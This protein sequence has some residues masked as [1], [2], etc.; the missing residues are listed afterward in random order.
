M[1]MHAAALE[2]LLPP[3]M[4][5]P[6]YELF[7]KMKSPRIMATHLPWQ[8]LPKQATDDKKGRLSKSGTA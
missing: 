7:K 5:V 2:I 3:D 8:F 4:K 6:A 1:S